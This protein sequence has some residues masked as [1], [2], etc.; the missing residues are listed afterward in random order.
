MTAFIILIS[1]LVPLIKERVDVSRIRVLGCMFTAFAFLFRK[2][3]YVEKKHQLD[4]DLIAPPRIYIHMCTLYTRTNTCMLRFSPSGF[5]GPSRCPRLFSTPGFT[6][7]TSCA[8]CVCVCVY[9]HIYTHTVP[10]HLRQKNEKT[11]TTPLSLLL[12]KLTPHAK[13]QVL[14]IN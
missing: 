3:R 7:S 10:G 2:K 5:F 9:T 1:S 4:Q 12:S 13:R 11:Q 8:V 6:S 14:S